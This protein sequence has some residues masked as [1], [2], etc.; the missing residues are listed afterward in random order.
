MLFRLE[1]KATFK[2]RKQ[3]HRILE[4]N[5]WIFGEEFALTVSDRSLTEVLR[6]HR[7]LVS[8]MAT[9]IVDDEPVLRPAGA[10]KGRRRR[11]TRSRSNSAT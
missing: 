5:T 2:E 3:L 1:L 10:P 8:G 4:T 6:K 11:G 7:D 9:A